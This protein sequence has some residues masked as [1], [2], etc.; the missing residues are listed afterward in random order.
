MTRA[1]DPGNRHAPA[2]GERIML[3]QYIH[4]RRLIGTTVQIRQHGHII[5][6]GTIDDAMADSTALWIAG[7]AT[8]PRTMYEAAHGIEVWADPEEAEDGLC[9]RMTSTAPS[10]N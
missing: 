1:T 4:W 8:Q 3:R 2:Y 7:D 10:H 5:R 6:T 9:Y